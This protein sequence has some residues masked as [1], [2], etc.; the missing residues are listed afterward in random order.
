MRKYGR[1]DANQTA[2]V[3]AL[4]KCGASV[5]I[6]SSVGGGVPDLLVGIRGRNLLMEVKDGAQSP[7]KRLLTPDELLWHS[8]WR[9]CVSVVLNV[10]DA[11]MAI[12]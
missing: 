7:S 1:V 4:R 3:A 2:I 11:V 5:Q 6:I 9:G 10:D 12:S 8:R